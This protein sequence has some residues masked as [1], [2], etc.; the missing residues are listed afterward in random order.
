MSLILQDDRQF[1][2]IAVQEP[3]VNPQMKTVYCPVGSR[4]QRVY[5]AGRAALYVHKR[6]GP[7]DWQ[8]EMGFDWCKVTLQGMTVWS[9]YSPIPK[10]Q[11]WESP[12][13]RLSGD[14]PAEPQLIVGDMNLHHPLW[15]RAGRTTPES[16]VLLNAASQWDLRLL[17]PW[18]EPTR[19]R[20]GDRD[21]TIDHAWLT[22]TAHGRFIGSLDY[23]GSDHR[24]QLVEVNAT[25]LRGSQR[26]KLATGWSWRLMDYELVEIEARQLRI[27]DELD[28]P[29]QLE[30]AVSQLTKQLIAVA[31]A[32]APQRKQNLG[33]SERW[34]NR[35][36]QEAVQETRRAQRNYR[37]GPTDQS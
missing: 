21:S 35:E 12:L 8:A 33:G 2:V 20:Y 11:Q 17:T 26:A 19:C 18:G 7:T 1:D 27:P 10:D 28:T 13:Q 5:G 37:A 31:D 24:A 6:H 9:I 29:Q 25:P 15:D 32:A 22:S 14:R 30:A 3:W 36:V 23:E 4:Y 34:W 16:E